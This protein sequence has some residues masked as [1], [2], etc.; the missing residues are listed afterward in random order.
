MPIIDGGI[1]V[2]AL[3]WCSITE[4]VLWI[5]FRQPPI[6]PIWEEAFENRLP[7]F[8]INERGEGFRNPMTYLGSLGKLYAHLCAGTVSLRGRPA[9]GP[10]TVSNGLFGRSYHCQKWGDVQLIEAQK[11]IQVGQDEFNT[12]STSGLLID[13]I[14]FPDHA[15]FESFYS[16]L[17]VDFTQLAERFPPNSGQNIRIGADIKTVEPTVSA[18]NKAGGGSKN[19]FKRALRSKKTASLT[20]KSRTI[21]HFDANC[22]IRTAEAAVYLGLSESTLEKYRLNGKGPAYKKFEKNC[23]YFKSDLDMWIALKSVGSTSKKK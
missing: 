22:G 17:C 13:T 21:S 18:D 8:G 16:N 3:E 5:E 12:A 19:V 9:I 7:T 6:E 2:P 11:I 23:V 14:F 20:Q 4:A 15:E 1:D 10:V